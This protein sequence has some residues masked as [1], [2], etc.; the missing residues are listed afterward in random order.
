MSDPTPTGR[1]A[2]TMTATA[3]PPVRMPDA[4]ILFG[5]KTADESAALRTD[6]GVLLHNLT[7]GAIDTFTAKWQD[8]NFTRAGGDYAACGD[9]VPAEYPLAQLWRHAEMP[10]PC[11][12]VGVLPTPANDLQIRIKEGANTIVLFKG[13]A[14]RGKGVAAL[15]VM[16]PPGGQTQFQALGDKSVFAAPVIRPMAELKPYFAEALNHIAGQCGC[17]EHDTFDL[18]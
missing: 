2:R 9:N 14:D 17:G 8:K 1:P 4:V 6:L 12:A 13:D 18:K 5:G 16:T 15:L 10:S 3:F 7:P 11:C